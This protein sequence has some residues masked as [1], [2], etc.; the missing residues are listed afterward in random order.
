MLIYLI[1]IFVNDTDTIKT[2]EGCNSGDPTT[3]F[4]FFINLL[5]GRESILL[6]L[7]IDFAISS[8]NMHQLYKITHNSLYC[9]TLVCIYVC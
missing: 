5:Y 7:C 1:F 6:F 2:I 9:P 4:F 3:I 8:I